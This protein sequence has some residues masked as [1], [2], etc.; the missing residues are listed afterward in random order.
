MGKLFGTDGIR[1]TAGVDLTTDLVARVGR[2]LAALCESERPRIV[3][4]RDTRV[5]G[6]AFEE[7]F[8]GGVTSGGGDVL[9]AGI[10][11]TA[12]VA[13]LTAELNADA[14]VVVSASHNPPDHNG[15]KIF[16]AGG[17]KLSASDEDRIERTVDSAATPGGGNVET[18]NDAAGRYLDHLTRDGRA[19]LSGMNVVIDCANGAASSFAPVAFERL[20]ADVVALHAEGDGSRINDGCG[21]LHPDVV[22]KV[23]KERNAIGITLDGDA[24][25]VLLVDETGTIV[26]GDG[27]IA[28]L[29][30]HMSAEGVV[31]TVMSNQALRRWCE[32]A[33]I[34]VVETPVGDRHVLNALRETGLLLGGEQAGHIARL[35]QMTTGDGILIGLDVC[36]SVAASGG[37]LADVVP[38]RPLPQVLINVPVAKSNGLDRSAHVRDAIAEAERKLGRDGRV[39]VRP[40]GTEPLVR[41]MVEAPDAAVAGEL[42]EIVADAVRRGAH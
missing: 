35:D 34:R 23:A 38:F 24:D 11:P 32:R 13:F 18:I 30:E 27:I 2:A 41:V 12:G 21:A 8:V 4:G 29:A 17:W 15:V 3:V 36:G 16:G 7:A 20:G 40:S 10:M 39:L 22:A 42:A 31:V 19:D 9:L 5:S 1:G 37:R 28:L 25:R 33:A 6:P 14:G 26:D